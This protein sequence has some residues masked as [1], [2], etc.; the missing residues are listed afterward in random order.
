MSVSFKA[1]NLELATFINSALVGGAALVGG[2]GGMQIS[3]FFSESILLQI[4]GS[5]VGAAVGAQVSMMGISIIKR[6]YLGLSEGIRATRVENVAARAFSDE[7][8][9]EE[10]V[11]VLGAGNFP[12]ANQV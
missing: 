3:S 8:N 1:V 5:I 2:T 4:F 11:G 9:E 12:V 7:P 10:S 6:D